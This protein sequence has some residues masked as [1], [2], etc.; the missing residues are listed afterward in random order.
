MGSYNWIV[1]LFAIGIFGLLYGSVYD[2]M[3]ELKGHA[4]TN[5]TESNKGVEII[6]KC[7]Q[8]LPL[9]CIGACVIYAI[10]SGQKRGGGW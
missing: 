9:G 6:W 1:I 10:L 8:F 7:W 3:G 2:V 4:Y 5:S